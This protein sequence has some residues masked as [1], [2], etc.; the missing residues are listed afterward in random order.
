MKDYFNYKN[1]VCVVTGAASGI[2]L[3]TVEML[4]DLGAKVYALDRNETKI[5]GIKKFIQTDL[6]HK[7]SIDEAFE[8]MPDNI[9]AFFGVAG[10]SGAI[11]NYYTTFTVNFIANKYITEEYLEKLE[12]KF[13]QKKVKQKEEKTQ[14][15]EYNKVEESQDEEEM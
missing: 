4:V 15:V 14:Q 2:G 8:K 12:E 7:E 3:A 5:K 10:L 13:T 11:T 9:D 6:S 1:K